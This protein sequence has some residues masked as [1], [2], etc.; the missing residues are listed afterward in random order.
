MCIVNQ[1]GSCK[2]RNYSFLGCILEY[3]PIE[4]DFFLFLPQKS[5]VILGEGFKIILVTAGKEFPAFVS[6]MPFTVC[7]MG[8]LSAVTE[9]LGAVL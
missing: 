3:Q 6:C 4:I 7:K 8:A 2:E 9:F 1:I 5:Y